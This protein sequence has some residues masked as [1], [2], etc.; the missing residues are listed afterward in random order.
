MN[1]WEGTLML[2]EKGFDLWADRYAKSVGASDEEG[3]Y[4]FAGL[5]ILGKDKVSLWDK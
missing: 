4:P 2:D 1:R 5:L 3:S